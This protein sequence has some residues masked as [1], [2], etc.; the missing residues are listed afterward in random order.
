MTSEGLWTCRSN[1]SLCYKV[2]HT[3]APFGDYTCTDTTFKYGE[4]SLEYIFFLRM[5][6][7]SSHK[8]RSPHI[9]NYS[10]FELGSSLA[11]YRAFGWYENSRVNKCRAQ[12]DRFSDHITAAAKE[13][14]CIP[15]STYG[16]ASTSLWQFY[17]IIKN[18]IVVKSFC[19]F[20]LL[21]SQVK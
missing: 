16:L 4:N 2:S 6:E 17:L 5:N 11:H 15:R 9:L 7:K 12:P 10:D 8:I 18:I 20:S 14:G 1:I 3:W 21:L 19:S 13:H